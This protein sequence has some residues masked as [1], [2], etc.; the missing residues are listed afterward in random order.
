MLNKDTESEIHTWQSLETEEHNNQEI[1]LEIEALMKTLKDKEEELY[2]IEKIDIEN[3]Q[4]FDSF[5][6]EAFTQEQLYKKANEAKRI[7]N[8]LEEVYKKGSKNK[9]EWQKF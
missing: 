6:Q 9:S 3:S 1:Y 7:R 4:N 2:Q 8:I 5:N